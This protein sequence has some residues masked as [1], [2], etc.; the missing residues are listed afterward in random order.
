[1]T[2]T[3]AALLALSV[4]TAGTAALADGTRQTTAEI[5]VPE[6]WQ[7]IYERWR[8]APAVKVGNTIYLS[9][10]VGGIRDDLPGDDMTAGF[11]RTFEAI[12]ET[13]EQAGASWDDVVEM[14]TY[15]TDV[16]GQMAAFRQVKDRFVRAPYPAWTAIDVDRLVP[17]NG[18]V[19][20]RVIAVISE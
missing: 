20:I 5:I 6:S 10:V 11:T 13:L 19:E 7:E 16:V 15:H 3:V 4:G 12:A 1:M 17:D 2:R 14:T 18:L 9:G 8:F